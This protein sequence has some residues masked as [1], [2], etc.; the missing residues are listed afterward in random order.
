MPKKFTR[1][2]IFYTLVEGFVHT[3][4]LVNWPQIDENYVVGISE[5]GVRK[6]PVLMLTLTTGQTFE[7]R[8][9]ELK[10]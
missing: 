7:V 9:K 2:D 3:R 4:D 6:T 10:G 1:Q 8:V 5:V